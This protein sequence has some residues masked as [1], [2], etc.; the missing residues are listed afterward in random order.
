MTSKRKPSRSEIDHE[1]AALVEAYLDD[2]ADRNG[3]NGK[4]VTLG[5]YA[6][7]RMLGLVGGRRLRDFD[8]AM[9]HTIR[10]G[11]IDQLHQPKPLALA[12]VANHLGW[13]RKFFSWLAEGRAPKIQ[14]GDIETIRLDAN[15]AR[16]LRYSKPTPRVQS[17]ENVR[18]ML[19]AIEGDGE[20][21]KR[22]RALIAVLAATGL[23]IDTVISMTVGC[24][25]ESSKVF[26]ID[27]A[28]HPQI[29]V[30]LGL[31]AKV[32]ILSLLPDLEE[33]IVGWWRH[34]VE[35]RRFGSSHPLFP[36]NAEE[37][38]GDEP[39]TSSNSARAILKQRAKAAGVPHSNPHSYRHM[40]GTVALR[41]I[42]TMTEFKALSQNLGHRSLDMTM[43]YGRLGPDEHVG[44]LKGVDFAGTGAVDQISEEGVLGEVRD[45][46]A[47][48]PKE[49]RGA[50]AMRVIKV[51]AEG[52][53][54]WT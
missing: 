32:T 26:D 1:N 20:R 9:A 16:S 5:A 31:P 2:M 24:F 38:V 22:D 35:Q 28:Q 12:T 36:R 15:Q 54:S 4:T 11:L 51:A 27:P 3:W 10:D 47:S 7:D 48:L 6:L 46:L 19:D 21:P 39:W 40:V 44:I 42:R 49:A 37:G 30:K 34:L 50:V 41:R 29:R 17:I 13:A 45:L 53:S 52:Q 25:D 18:A 8:R 23:R 43:S 14:H 33:H